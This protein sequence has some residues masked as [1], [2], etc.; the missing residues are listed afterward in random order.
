MSSTPLH[1][2]PPA[3]QLTTAMLL[4]SMGDFL[5]RSKI[6]LLGFDA[7]DNGDAIIIHISHLSPPSPPSIFP[8]NRSKFAAAA[9][10]MLLVDC[11]VHQ[12]LFWRDNGM[13]SQRNDHLIG[14]WCGVRQ[15][16][17]HSQFH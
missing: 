5:L 14:V 2:H 7:D 9:L 13:N 6:A 10:T 12:V 3:R 16:Y 17:F 11:C 1:P 8:F 15:K 4:P